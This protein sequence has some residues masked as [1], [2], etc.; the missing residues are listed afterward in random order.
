M[1]DFDPGANKSMPHAKLNELA[2]RKRWGELEQEWLEVIERPDVDP[3]DLLPVIDAVV[4]ANQAGL[5]ATMGWAWL[6]T[7]KEQH[8]AREALTLGRGLLLRLPDGDQLRDEILSLYVETH[9]DRGDLDWWVE[10]AGLKSGK[11]VRR[12]LRF[13][14]TGLKLA[15]GTPLFHRSEDEAARVVSTDMDADE[16]EIRTARRTHQMSISQAVEDYDV[17]DENDFQFLQ[18]LE[19][20]RIVELAASDPVALLIGL[21][22]NHGP[23]IDRDELKLM[24]VPA[25]IKPGNWSSWWTRVRNA[26][27][28][29]PQLR[30]EGRS[31]ML[32]IYD[33]AG[34][35]PEAETWQALNQSSNPRAWLDVLEGYLRSTER[36]AAE[37]N[38][39]F[40]KRVQSF[41]VDHIERFVRHKDPGTALATALVIERLAA[42]GL[43]ISTDSHGVALKMLSDVDDPVQL[44]ASLPD[45]RLWSLGIQ[46]VE[47]AFPEKWPETLATSILYAPGA[48]ID[49]LAKSVEKAGRGDL[50]QPVIERAMA[51]PGRHTDA[52]MWLWK[53]PKLETALPVP[54]SLELFNLIMSLVG[55]ARMSG[56]KAAGQSVN[57]MRSRVRAGLSARKFARF[58][59]CIAAQPEAMAPAIRRLV[60]RADGLGITVRD[61]MLTI[62]RERFPQMYVQNKVP[63][64]QDESVLYFSEAGLRARQGEINELVNVKMRD[65]ARAIGEA[66]AHGD[67]SENSEYKFA[68]EERD[69][70]RARLKQLNDEVSIA[71]V[72]KP[73]RV[74]TDHVNIGQQVRLCPTNGGDP[75]V[76]TL[77][78]AGESDTAAG[79][80]FYKSP[81]AQSILGKK[82]GEAVTLSLSGEEAEY[83]VERIDNAL[84]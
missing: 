18:R 56:G 28:K 55:P 29:S 79:V 64:W 17:V 8:S 33:E 32:L 24:L 61:E 60:E 34:R 36:K 68:L 71:R 42:D 51:D 41:L 53:G 46:C 25:F 19:P 73:D 69:L 4:K 23:Q 78:G 45:T 3:A 52:V 72:I 75:V 16:V 82:I 31:P 70:L 49:R 37:A 39:A 14:D 44:L 26:V 7:M 63:M 38:A 57:N 76:M 80:Y 27:K 84:A 65:N 30:I 1:R 9:S 11:S 54:A 48:L 35:T 5:A 43:P 21:L 67:L 47:Q 6:S 81:L 2:N 62:L 40:F 22:K 83:R 59:E 58:H 15:P 20:N 74:A 66:A 50:L 13:L 10:R 77:A 12:A